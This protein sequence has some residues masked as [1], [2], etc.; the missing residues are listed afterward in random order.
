MDL[1]SEAHL[2]TAAVRILH[3]RKQTQP[4]VDD[5]C[6]MLGIS[7][8]HGLSVARKLADKGILETFEDPFSIRLGLGDHLLI[9]DLPRTETEESSLS[10]ELAQFMAKKKSEE[11]KI[12]NIQAE[13]DKKKKSM[14]NDIEEKLKKQFP[15]DNS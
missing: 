6:E 11:R 12:E 14:F 5:L 15:G 1:Y 9:E 7:V 10:D 3:H 4:S 2:F 13:L 8:E